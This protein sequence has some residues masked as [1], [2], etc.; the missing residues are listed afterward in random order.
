MDTDA[1]GMRMKSAGP[2]AVVL[3]AILADEWRERRGALRRS[4][5]A[6]HLIAA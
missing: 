2:V 5:A 4:L 3:L 1:G 6:A